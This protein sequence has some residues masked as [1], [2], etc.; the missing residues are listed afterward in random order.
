MSSASP[1]SPESPA[2]PA[3][4]AHDE[5]RNLIHRYAEAV[6]GG[7]FEVLGE[8]FAAATVRVA[9]GAGSPGPAMPGSSVVAM[10]GDGI[11]LYADGTPRTRHL[12]TNTI[13]DVDEEGG[14]ATA[15][16]YNTTLQQVPGRSIEIIATA[17]YEDTF[18]RS[19]GAWRFCERII[20]H[21]SLDG[22]HRDFIGDMSRHT[23]SAAQPADG[24]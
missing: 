9:V 6:D 13:I 8:L 3:S 23:R 19:G 22:V 2:S 16:S 15:R 10:F 21:S 7:R 1:E 17:R 11:I 12:V 20:R 5:I 24:T 14:R 18:E 4:F